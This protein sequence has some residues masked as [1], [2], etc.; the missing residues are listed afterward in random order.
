MIS[1]YGLHVAALFLGWVANVMS[2]LSGY[3]D[4]YSFSHVFTDPVF[5]LSQF[6][7]LI[8]TVAPVEVFKAYGRSFI[9][10][11]GESLGFAEKQ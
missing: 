2:M 11:F 9:P 7:M 8:A 10:T 4:P 6:L 1:I 5:W 3:I